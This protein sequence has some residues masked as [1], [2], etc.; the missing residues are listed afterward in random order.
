MGQHGYGAC[1]GGLTTKIHMAVDALSRPLEL[2][3]MPGQRGDAPLALALL[4]GLSPRRVLAENAYDSNAIRALVADLGAEAVIP[5]NPTRKRLIAYD[6]EAYKMRNTVERC[7]N[8]LKH[9]R[10][11]AMRLDR[12]AIHLLG[13]RKSQPPCS[14]CAECRFNL[15]LLTAL[16]APSWAVAGQDALAR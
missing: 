12:R 15:G 8:K 1:R 11:I 16:R 7:F 9:F 3:L 6:A 10:R 2:I 13:F 14:G 4:N 5:C